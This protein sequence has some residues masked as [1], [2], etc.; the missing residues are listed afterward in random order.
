[1]KVVL[2]LENVDDVFDRCGRI[3]GV[4]EGLHKEFWKKLAEFDAL[5]L[6]PFSSCSGFTRATNSCDRSL[7]G[8]DFG[9]R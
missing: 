2:S 8:F 4:G 6:M 3:L 9:P 5:D 7:N 1:M